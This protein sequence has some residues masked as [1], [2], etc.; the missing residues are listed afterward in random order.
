MQRQIAAARKNNSTRLLLTADRRRAYY[1][2]EL[3]ILV[4]AVAVAVAAAAAAAPVAVVAPS[5]WSDAMRA[6]IRELLRS[7]DGRVTDLF[8]ARRRAEAW[9]LAVNADRAQQLT[10]RAR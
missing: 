2:G 3:T 10:A 9:A 4:L 7:G 8:G 5:A 1:K 6:M